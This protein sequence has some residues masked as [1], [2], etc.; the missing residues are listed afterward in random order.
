[1]GGRPPAAPQ[2][3]VVHKLP[4]HYLLKCEVQAM[5]GQ[6]HKVRGSTQS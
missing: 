4:A 2:Q 1:M 5:L 3:L 6:A